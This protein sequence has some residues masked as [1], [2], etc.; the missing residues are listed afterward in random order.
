MILAISY[1]FYFV[2]R[3]QHLTSDMLKQFEN[4]NKEM[5]ETQKQRKDQHAVQ[6]GKQQNDGDD[7]DDKKEKEDDKLEVISPTTT[8]TVLEKGESSE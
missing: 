3:L 7:D 1:A 4:D 5:N 8:T 6:E 2:Y